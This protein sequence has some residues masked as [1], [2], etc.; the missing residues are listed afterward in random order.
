MRNETADRQISLISRPVYV[1]L[2]PKIPQSTWQKA[3]LEHILAY[4]DVNE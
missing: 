1:K 2:Y 4:L 3:R